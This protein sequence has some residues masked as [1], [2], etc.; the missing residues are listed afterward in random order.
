MVALIR[1]SMAMYIMAG[2][3]RIAWRGNMSGTKALGISHPS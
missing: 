1:H 2:M 3:N